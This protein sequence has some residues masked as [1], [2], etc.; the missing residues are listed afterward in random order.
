MNH[1]SFDPIKK[2]D[3]LNAN[4]LPIPTN[5]SDKTSNILYFFNESDDLI[6]IGRRQGT[7]LE[8]GQYILDTAKKYQASFYTAEILP[9]EDVENAHAERVLS[10]KPYGNKS[11]PANT[12]FISIN[13]AKEFY[14]INKPQ[15][16]RFIKEVRGFEFNGL[17]YAYKNEFLEYFELGGEF[18]EF[19]P[20][21]GDEIITYHFKHFPQCTWGGADDYVAAPEQTL[22]RIE[23]PDGATVEVVTTSF[24]GKE[25]IIDRLNEVFDNLWRVVEVKHDKFRA[26]NNQNGKIENFMADDYRRTWANGLSSYTKSFVKSKYN[27]NMI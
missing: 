10:F 4:K 5:S 6:Y 24:A 15:F 23:E 22:E 17:L 27:I 13:K 11:L 8:I 19:M 7:K 25:E 14:R 9:D 26:Q 20:K 18:K 16:K 12:I 1:L 3:E 2:F 21:I